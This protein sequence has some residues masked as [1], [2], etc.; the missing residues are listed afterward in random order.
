MAK[1]SRILRLTGLALAGLS[2]IVLAAG[3]VGYGVLQTR[4]VKDRAAALIE[5]ALQP[6]DGKIEIGSLGGLLPQRIRLGDVSVSDRDGVWLRIEEAEIDWS[7][8]SLLLG[9]QI[10]AQ[11]LKVTRPHLLRGPIGTDTGAED[12]PFLP[13]LPDIHIIIRTFEV[14]DLMI[15]PDVAGVESYFD[16][17]GHIELSADDD[18]G[19]RFELTRRT[20]SEA[21]LSADI[22]YRRKEDTLSIDLSA[23]ELGGGPWSFLLGWR[24]APPWRV[25]FHGSGP[26]K[27]WKGRLEGSA[28]AFGKMALNLGVE[29]SQ[30]PRITLNGTVDVEQPSNALSSAL[31]APPYNL[32]ADLS[33]GEAN[34]IRVTTGHVS[35]AAGRLEISGSID[36][37]QGTLDIPFA[38]RPQ[39]LK[40]L[41]ALLAPVSGRGLSLGGRLSGKVSAPSLSLE[42]EIQDFA[43][44]TVRADKAAAHGRALG[45]NA[46]GTF[47]VEAKAELDGVSNVQASRDAVALP[48]VRFSGRGSVDD[49]LGVIHI[50]TSEI[51]SSVG[52]LRVSGN[53]PIDAKDPRAFQLSLEGEVTAAPFESPAIEAFLRDPLKIRAEIALSKAQDQYRVSEVLVDHP[54]IRITGSA[55]LPLNLSDLGGD[56]EAKVEDID[57]LARR[58]ELPISGGAL[59][60]TSNVK[61]AFGVPAYSA[62]MTAE[63]LRVGDIQLAPLDS[64]L[65]L[66]SSEQGATGAL[67]ASLGGLPGPASLSANLTIAGEHGAIDIDA[68]E[69]VGTGANFG[70]HMRL[71]S[72][73]AALEGEI[74]GTI[75]ELTP[76]TTK[77]GI[78][79]AGSASLSATFADKLSKQ[80]IELQADLEQFRLA[81]P[82]FENLAGETASVSIGRADEGDGIY[83]FALKGEQGS[84]GLARLDTVSLTGDMDFQVFNFD[85]DAAG[86]FRGDLRVSAAGQLDFAPQHLSVDLSRLN[87]RIFETDI[88]LLK[89]ARLV[90]GPDGLRLDPLAMSI[91]EGDLKFAGYYG[92]GSLNATMELSRVQL[93]PISLFVPQ[94]ALT[95]YLS[96]EASLT[97]SGASPGGK[98][99]FALAELTAVG[100][101]EMAPIRGALTGAWNAGRMQFYITLTDN[102]QSHLKANGEGPLVFDAT[103]TQFTFPTEGPVSG[104]LSWRGDL[105]PVWDAFGSESHQL[106]GTVDAK[107]TL[108]G[109]AGVPLASGTVHVSGGSYLNYDLGTVLKDIDLLFEASETELVLREATASDGGTGKISAR[110]HVLLDPGR[111]FPAEFELTAEN[112]TLARA[113]TVTV[114]G[115]GAL[116]YSRQRGSALLSGAVTANEIEALL[117]DIATVDIVDLE[118]QEIGGIE[119]G[120]SKITPPS[121]ALGVETQLD[122]T[123]NV[124]RRAFIRGR[125]LDS[126]WKGNIRAT[127]TAEAPI[128]TGTLDLVRGRFEFAGRAFTITRG[129]VEFRGGAEID[130]WI[131]VESEYRDN[132]FKALAQI[133]GPASSPKITLSADPDLPQDE[134]MARILFGTS[135]SELGPFEAVQLADAVRTLT[136][137]GRSKGLLGKARGTIGLDVFRIGGNGEGVAGTTVTGGKYLT[138]NIYIEVERGLTGE[139]DKISVEVQVTPSISIESELMQDTGG[140][141]GV[142]WRKDY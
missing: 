74:T 95:G 19:L 141:I 115:G 131:I 3:L 44:G 47:L 88:A 17:T 53:I 111:K 69:F 39:N 64:S 41:L 55:L 135:V 121:E 133:S 26:L 93:R 14:D 4:W 86:L 15:D 132:D 106:R 22:V 119:V 126:E 108:S 134:I 94:M 83:A 109:T 33:L 92:A 70:G 99:N 58:F 123:A 80:D 142:K 76:W 118:V 49:S 128:L 57:L 125:G 40:R 139:E 66:A 30:T 65:V 87:G 46:D 25:D 98:L 51:S 5:A 60:L 100:Y 7:P 127:G 81:L 103:S 79:L 12:D 136:S 1:R 84:L 105:G 97:S 36:T 120:N 18:L 29:G 27:N 73:D 113:Q 72:F 13:A 20:R 107:A 48:S 34:R 6:E 75:A 24:D 102:A 10:D 89:P 38:Y 104:T 85:L 32:N 35:N 45:I 16:A 77:F 78:P 96:G 54:L 90:Q 101:P 31:V 114:K 59:S 91:G 62:R 2:T 67:K 61:S 110:G 130:P 122:I 56:F 140:N 11:S 9:D 23:R 112:A 63:D 43:A 71:A 117:I 68:F 138:D 129:T 50:D 124:P 137:P 37:S 116:N 8:L 28:E 82:G 52:T 42:A 21:T